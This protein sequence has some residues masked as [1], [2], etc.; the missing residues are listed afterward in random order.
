MFNFACKKRKKGGGGLFVALLCAVLVLLAVPSFAEDNAS[1]YN[2]PVT[3]FEGPVGTG[4]VMYQGV[5]TTLTDANNDSAGTHYTQAMFI[6]YYTESDAYWEAVAYNSALGTEAMD[7]YVEFSDDR[8][9]WWVGSQSSGKIYNDLGTTRVADTLNIQL[10]VPDTYFKTAKWM[11]FKWTGEATNPTL[12]Y[13]TWKV[14]FRKPTTLNIYPSY[15][16]RNK[17]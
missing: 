17:I 12:T 10:A 4:V 14:V 6:A 5:T 3:C 1:I 8:T 2:D 7:M 11:R 15:I 9:T 16:I 13:V